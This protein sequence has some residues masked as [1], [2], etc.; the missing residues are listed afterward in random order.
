MAYRFYRPVFLGVLLIV[1]NGCSLLQRADSQ[2]TPLN[3][4]MREQ[5]IQ[6]MQQFELQASVGIKT[7]ADS[8]SGNLR[9]QQHNSSHYNARL[10]N[11]GISL[12][13]LTDT[14][15]G[16]A[17]TIKGET[18]RAVDTSTLLLQLSGWSMPLN[19]MPLW[20][21][22]LP[23][24]KGRDVQRDAEGRVTGFNLTDSTGIVWQL[25]YQSFFP[26]SL[27]LPKR[28]LLQSDDSQIKIVI[29]SWQ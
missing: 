12:F 23:G 24:S 1:L 7:P 27:A 25:Q 15:Q 3:S 21:R 28:L 16:S 19:D 22:G 10:S 6:A 11:V 14:A 20:L 9:W 29:R 5:K 8:V 4:T 17:I 2:Q 13:E 18:Y 26:D